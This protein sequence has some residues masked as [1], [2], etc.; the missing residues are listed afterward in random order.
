M[1]D[2]IR[3]AAFNWLEKQTIYDDVLSWYVL[4]QGFIYKGNR[5]NLVG[6]SGI[7]KPQVFSKVPLS[8]TTSPNSPY[9]DSLTKEG[10]L[11][12]KYRDRGTNPRRRFLLGEV[13]TGNLYVRP[14]TERQDWKS[15]TS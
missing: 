9:D 4:Q 14:T 13:L 7:W 12:Y 1:E 6:A 5:I 10:F 15:L 3:L 11:N 2:Q 8:I